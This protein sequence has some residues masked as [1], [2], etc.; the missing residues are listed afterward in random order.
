MSDVLT[1]LLLFPL[2]WVLVTLFVGR[3]LPEKAGP[4]GYAIAMAGAVLVSTAVIGTP[5]TKGAL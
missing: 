4:L 3:L 2:P 5:S 1:T